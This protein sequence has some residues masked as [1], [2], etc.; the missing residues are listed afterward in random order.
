MTLQ[1]LGQSI[2]EKR[3]AAGLTIDDVAARIKI[4]TRILKSIEEG[5]LVGLPHAVYTKS[6]IRSFGLLVG[7]DPEELNPRLDTL[8]PPESLDETRSEPTFRSQA[9]MSYPSAGRRFAALLIML[10]ILGGLVAGG[11]YVTV[12]Y[13]DA[14][15]DL[16]KKPFSALSGPANGNGQGQENPTTE[17]SSTT[18]QALSNTLSALVGTQA[19]SGAARTAPIAAPLSEPSAA[20]PASDTDLSP[21]RTDISAVAS[22]ASAGVAASGAT[23]V[24]ERK[25]SSTE[26]AGAQSPQAS[27]Q[28]VQAGEN[29]PVSPGE[30]PR[31]DS[32]PAGVRETP[33]AEDTVSVSV[34]QQDDTPL[35]GGKKRLLIVAQEPCWVGPRVDG[36]KGRDFILQSGETFVF[37]YTNSLELTLGNAGGVTLEHNGQKQGSP[38]RRGQRVVLRFPAP[39]R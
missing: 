33:L 24:P 25:F 22:P 10:L 37:A 36:F 15:L 31:E 3:E 7:Y 32:G 23:S 28:T 8:F 2:R 18:S 16:V 27:D 39:T 26:V 9:A 13:G 35:P 11:W 34:A 19:K 14:I 4:S 21:P 30:F 17:G 1:E 6:F 12:H 38:G 5:S 29:L 20:P